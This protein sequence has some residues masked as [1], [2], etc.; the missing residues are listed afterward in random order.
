[1][2]FIKK[3]HFF[4]NLFKNQSDSYVLMLFNVKELLIILLRSY[5]S[6]Y[7]ASKFWAIFL[8]YFFYLISY[9]IFQYLSQPT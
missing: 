3:N 8:I 6:N 2:S 4:K 1:M 7:G 5:K 9:F